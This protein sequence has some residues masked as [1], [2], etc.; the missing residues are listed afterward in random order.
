VY[1]YISGETAGTNR[2]SNLET[3]SKELYYDAL[4]AVIDNRLQSS[5]S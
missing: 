3:G 5:R 4:S 2:F 1:L